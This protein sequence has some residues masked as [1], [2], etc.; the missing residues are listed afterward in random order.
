MTAVVDL[1][2]QSDDDNSASD[3]P[4]SPPPKRRAVRA[5][6]SDPATRVRATAHCDARLYSNAER[7]QNTTMIALRQF[8]QLGGGP[9][10]A[11]RSRAAAER[12]ARRRALSRNEH[13]CCHGNGRWARSTPRRWPTAACRGSPPSA[14]HRAS[15]CCGRASRTRRCSCRS[16]RRPP[17][18][19][20]MCDARHARSRR[21]GSA[22]LC[23]STRTRTTPTC[24]SR[25]APKPIAR[26]VSGRIERM[27]R[28]WRRM[29]R[30][31]ARVARRGA[32]AGPDR[33]CLQRERERERLQTRRADAVRRR[34]LWAEHSAAAHASTS[35]AAVLPARCSVRVRMPN[36]AVLER[37][38]D[39]A[40]T[41]LRHLLDWCLLEGQLTHG[42][43]A[44]QFDIAAHRL[45]MRYPRRHIV[46]AE[47]CETCVPSL[48]WF[49]H[50]YDRLR[51]AM[52]SRARRRP[53]RRSRKRSSDRVW[54]SRSRSCPTTMYKRDLSDFGANCGRVASAERD[55]IS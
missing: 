45:V 7:N 46:A 32:P 38:F 19:C 53:T 15:R 41:T 49:A 6:A 8:A 26:C 54:H 16:A 51:T 34:A 39:A 35:A 18:C 11:L 4:C 52:R 25:R 17:N 24:A 5:L 13:R 48:V 28:R 23:A 44:G 9:R 36:G 1:T 22:R 2:Q 55:E 42:R 37:Q 12:A 29:K 33:A 43:D 20:A 3:M 30:C 40:H 31:V 10:N 50:A 27:S 21:G 47:V 14:T